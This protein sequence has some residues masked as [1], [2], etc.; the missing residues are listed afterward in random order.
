MG[1][2]NSISDPG[3][4]F[5]LL[6]L[7][8]FPFYLTPVVTFCSDGAQERSM[9]VSCAALA[10]TTSSLG[11]FPTGSTHNVAQGDFACLSGPSGCALAALAC[12]PGV[13]GFTEQLTLPC[14]PCKVLFRPLPCLP[15]RV[16]CK[17]QTVWQGPEPVHF[18][19]NI[20]FIRGFHPQK[21]R[22]VW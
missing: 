17:R 14:C 13:E 3:L 20:S 9:A 10:Q 11:T 2:N 4:Q 6:G 16:T 7:L 18:T 12:W 8:H 21:R 22:F 1:H 15:F 5:A 19:R